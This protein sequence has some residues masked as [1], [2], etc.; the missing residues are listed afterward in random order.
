MIRVASW[1]GTR[2]DFDTTAEALAWARTHLAQW[3]EPTDQLR[4]FEGR[5]GRTQLVVYVD[6]AEPT[7]ACVEIGASSA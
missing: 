6:G 4:R 5:D 7:D 2:R 3:M 1:D